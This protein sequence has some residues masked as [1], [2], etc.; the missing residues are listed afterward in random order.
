[1]FSFDKNLNLES[2]NMRTALFWVIT[3]QVVV[4]YYRRFGTNFQS[5]LPGSKIQGS[6]IL[7][8]LDVMEKLSRNVGKELLLYVV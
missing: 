4:I 7:D 6:W 2:L 8:T 1:M 3:Q 5:H